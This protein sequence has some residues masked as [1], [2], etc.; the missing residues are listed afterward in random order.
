MWCENVDRIHQ[1][2]DMSHFFI[3]PEVHS[4][5]MRLITY[6]SLSSVSSLCVERLFR[7]LFHHTGTNTGTQW[8]P[9]Y[10][11][12]VLKR[13]SWLLSVSANAAPRFHSCAPNA[14][15]I[16][17]LG[18][19]LRTAVIAEGQ[20]SRLELIQQKLVTWWSR[21]ATNTCCGFSCVVMSSRI[22]RGYDNN[23]RQRESWMILGLFDN[24]LS[25]IQVIWHRM[26][27]RKL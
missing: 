23:G 9:D 26:I 11:R 18:C 6:Q 7:S 20:R 12:L 8:Q 15:L 17:S 13:I 24:D 3:S 1:A 14:S 4:S 5:Q 10:I 2:Q 19:L 22:R 25:A 27:C 16:L 21:S